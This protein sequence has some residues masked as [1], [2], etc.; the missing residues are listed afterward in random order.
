[1]RSEKIALRKRKR[2]IFLLSLALG[3]VVVLGGLIT[4]ASYRPSL[5]ITDVVIHGN[6]VISDSQIREV[7]TASLSGK[8]FFLF[9]RANTAIYP[10]I[11]IESEILNRFRQ[12]ASVDI[13]RR[14]LKTLSFEIEEQKPHALWC[15]TMSTE[16]EST[17]RDCYFINAD[18]LVFSKAPNFTGNVFFRFHG[19]V[20]EQEPIGAYYLKVNNEF[21]KIRVLIDSL[22][23]SDFGVHPIELHLLGEDD[24]EMRLEDGGKILFARKQSSSEVLDNL[25]T[26]LLSETFKKEAMQ[27]I[28]Y[29]DLRFGNK[30]YFKLR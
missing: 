7:V 4:W 2:F 10:E 24:I 5:Q 27:N 9:P 3:I 28:E 17:A 23:G 1:M 18:G 19:D 20:D 6:S 12:I 16:V 13:V 26:V 22:L 29:I 8:Y 15:V 21:N 25:K 30:V 11:E 14:D